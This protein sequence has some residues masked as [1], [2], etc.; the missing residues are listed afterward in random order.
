MFNQARWAF[1]DSIISHDGVGS[2]ER[3][4]VTGRAVQRTVRPAPLDAVIFATPLCY[5][6]GRSVLR[7]L[8]PF[9]PT[10]LILRGSEQGTYTAAHQFL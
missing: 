6:E 1:V 8:G 5:P 2:L 10:F 9:F 3:A 4:Y 7:S